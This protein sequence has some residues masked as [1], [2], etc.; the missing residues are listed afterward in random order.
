MDG[1]SE[2]LCGVVEGFYGRP[3]SMEQRKVLFQWMQRW[4]LNTYLYG[5]KDDLKHRLLWREVYSPEEEGQ[6]RT[7]IVES[8][9]RGLRFVYSLS[10]GQDIVFSSA[11][12]LSL[13]KRKLRQVS[14]LG[15]QAFAILFDDIDHS[16]CQADSQAFSSFA[17][18]QVSVANEIY[19]FL[20][21][22]PVF[23]FCPTEYCGSLCSPSVSKSPYLMTVGED[24]LPNISII[25]TGSKVISRELSVEGL[26]EVQSVLQRPPL[27]WDNLHANDYDSRR[28]F[29]GPFKGRYPQLATQLRGLLL[30]PNCEFEANYIPLHTLG[31]WYREWM[32]DG[33][34]R[35]G[36]ERDEGEGGRGM[37]VGEGGRRQGGGKEHFGQI[38]DMVLEKNTHTLGT[39]TLSEQQTRRLALPTGG[40]GEERE[41]KLHNNQFQQGPG[42]PRSPGGVLCVGKAPLSESQIRL[43]VGLHYLPHEHGPSAQRLL[44]DLTW[45]KEHCHLVSAN[46]KK[47][48]PQKV[49]VSAEE[50][51]GRAAG[52]LGVCEE[53]AALHSSVVSGVS[54][55][56]LYDLYPYVWDLRN[57]ALV[58]KAFICWLGCG[59]TTGAEL[60]GVESEPWVFKGG[61][62]GELQMLLPI[63][64]NSELFSHPPPLFPTSRLYNIRPYHNKDKAELYCMVRQLQ[65]GAQGSPNS[66]PA[67]PDLIGDRCLGPCLALC[68]EYSM[69]LEDELGVC[70]CVLGVVDVRSFAKRCQTC[71]MPA[72]RD[73]YPPRTGHANSQEVLQQMEEDQGEYP[74]SLLYHFPSQLRLDALPD[75]VDISVT[76][77]L[78]TALLTAL[79]ANG[80][81]GVFCEMQPTDRMRLDFLTKLGFLEIIRGEARHREGV[82]LGRL[83]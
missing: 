16:L 13:L 17:H 19:R 11:C 46:D 26:S 73:K 4:E 71:W 29:L 60:L 65:Q 28:L 83:L 78:L 23:L 48:P 82:V 56:V 7:L 36:E 57:T 22:P 31:T 18:A 6:L 14:K 34:G 43:L 3:W 47:G 69:V 41:K 75:L 35:E 20:G 24:L 80:S 72:M 1:R 32:R 68:P 70:G 49:C 21:E 61:V 66:S 81:H 38:S 58:A 53:I 76:R 33:G 27:V 45:L 44:Q 8:E 79:K 63:G 12:D 51:R 55:A 37:I 67:H 25:W 62:S 50:W 9:K 30:N 52:F 59:T 5:P 15:C 40:D 77:C 74:D 39:L 10:P 64:S 42:Q 2:F 54:K